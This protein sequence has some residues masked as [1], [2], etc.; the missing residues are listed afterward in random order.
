[1]GDASDNAF[2]YQERQIEEENQ[3]FLAADE[4]YLDRQVEKYT[5]ED[6][7]K[8]LK[9]VTYT[10]VTMSKKEVAESTGIYGTLFLVFGPE[11]SNAIS[12][13]H[14]VKQDNRLLWRPPHVTL[15]IGGQEKKYP[16]FKG[17]LADEISDSGREAYDLIKKTFGKAQF[18]HTYRVANGK[19]VDET[20]AKEASA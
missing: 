19:V 4:E 15:S 11:P 10:L 1:M 7:N 3:A 8:L 16:V 12:Q 14:L 17:K 5:E 2:E 9:G 18:G 13:I 20:A 6:M